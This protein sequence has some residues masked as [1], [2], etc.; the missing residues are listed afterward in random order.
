MPDLFLIPAEEFTRVRA[1]VPDDLQLIADMCRANTL[2][3]VKRAGS[4]HLGSSLSS[5]DIATFLYYEELNTV[6]LGFLHPDRDVYFSSKGHDVPAQYAILHSLGLLD[7]TKF[8][9]LRRQSGTPGH[10]DV[11]VAGIEANTG[12]LGMGVSKGKGFA[13]AKRFTGRGGRVVVMTGDGELQE[14]QNYEAFHTA[15][16][17]KLTNLIV[18]V[19]ANELQSDKLCREICD[20][21]DIRAKLASF[22]WYVLECDGHDFDALRKAFREAATV[23]DRPKFLIARTIKGRGI[24]FMEH[25]QALQ[26]DGGVYRWHSGAPD[27]DSYTRAHQELLEKI[28]SRAAS[29]SLPKVRLEAVS[30]PAPAPACTHESVIEAYGKS[31]RR[32][33]SEL[34]EVVVLDADLSADCRVRGIEVDLPERFIENGIA[35]QD[36]VSMAGGLALAGYLPVVNSFAAFLAARANE[37][38]YANNTEGRKIVYACNY[39]GVLPAGPGHSHQS[40]RDISLLAS[41]P[42]LAI[43]QPCNA[44]ETDLGL[45]YLL[46]EFGSSAAIRLYLGMSPGAINLPPGYQVELGKGSLLKAGEQAWILAY[47][48]VLVWEALRAATILAPEFSVGVVNVPW[49]NRIDLEWLESIVGQARQIFVLEDHAP[50][51]GLAT[52]L[53]LEVHRTSRMLDCRV[54]QFAV[55]G[56]PDCGSAQDVLKFHGLDAETIAREIR[57]ARSGSQPFVAAEAGG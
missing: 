5:I 8:I 26:A 45:T 21:G 10:P 16:A 9:N 50:F 17:Q 25:P 33:V 14:G 38:I 3:S 30:S 51:G 15:V 1:S 43:F 12:S 47:G 20:L 27:D 23:V 2:M 41:L 49:L 40:V 48:P 34:P 56:V 29:H 7:T 6:E 31:L 52:T 46:K 42:D 13:W 19:D 35:E 54:H 22:G 11:R 24:S 39:A 36:M 44:V 53:L 28:Q 32:L 57:D 37:Q 18:V 4:G 55:R